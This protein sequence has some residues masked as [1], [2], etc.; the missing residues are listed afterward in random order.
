MDVNRRS[1][2]HRAP[3]VLGIAF[4]LFL[5]LFALD[6]F[7]EENSFL[8]I[9]KGLLFGLIPAAIMLISVA[10]ASRWER[11]GGSIYVALG[12]FYLFG[13]GHVHWTAYFLITG[14]A[15]LI[16]LLFWIDAYVN[17]EAKAIKH[18]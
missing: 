11:I 2:L 7:S 3:R 17:A 6:A 5:A 15:I 10:I 12:L 14:S 18:M 9:V 13:F 8:H 4:A 1:L 16:G